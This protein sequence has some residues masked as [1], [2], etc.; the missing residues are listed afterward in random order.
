MINLTQNSLTLNKT[1]PE[2][3]D[4][5]FTEGDVIIPDIK[6]DVETVIYVD[7][8]PV[9]DNYIVN[10]GQ[11]TISGNTEFNILYVSEKLPNEIIRISTSIPFK[12]S[13]AVNNLTPESFVEVNICPVKT[14][15]LILNGRKIN[16]S[17]ELQTNIKISDKEEITFVDRVENND[18][19]KQLLK[20]TSLPIFEGAVKSSTTVRDTAMLDTDKPTIKDILKYDSSI[21]KEETVISDEKLLLKAELHIKIYYTSENATDINLFEAILPFSNFI[22]VKNISEDDIY[23]L[24]NAVKRLSIK[25]LPDS[26][27]L[28]RIIEFDTDVESSLKT[29]HTG[30]LEIIEDIYST[31]TDLIPQ[32]ENISFEV[33]TPTKSEDITLRG[34][35][36]IPEDENVKILTSMGRIKTI[37]LTEENNNSLLSGIIDVTVIYSVPSTGKINSVSLDMPM[38]HML[39][40]NIDTLENAQIESIDVTSAGGEKYDV[41]ILLNVRGYENKKGEVSILRDLVELETPPEKNTGLTIYF[42]KPGDTLWKIAKRFHTT[43][44]HISEMNNIAEPDNIEAG[45]S[46]II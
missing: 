4:S 27:D 16:V 10:S 31:E 34:T 40:E 42:I 33:N 44:E 23:E 19:I 7:A 43:I 29:F 22:D 1:F 8:L 46:L 15:S 9:T 13:F 14:S 3:H 6:P 32:R 17:A 21:E 12:N 36:S 24:S 20:T 38:E 41:K 45:G 25:L 2:F 11:I 26:D 35:I 30:D 37:N 39:N 28:M 5:F 18:S